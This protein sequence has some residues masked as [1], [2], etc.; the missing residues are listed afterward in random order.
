MTAIEVYHL[1][2]KK[3]DIDTYKIVFSRLTYLKYEMK[4]VFYFYKLIYLLGLRL[5][6]NHC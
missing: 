5:W 3:S 4:V 6:E 2:Y 1:K